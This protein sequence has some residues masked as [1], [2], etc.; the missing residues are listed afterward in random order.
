MEMNVQP[1][2]NSCDFRN[3][4]PAMVDLPYP[5][6]QVSGKNQRYADLLSIDYCGQSSEMSAIMQYINQENKLAYEKCPFAKI[7]L[8]IAMSEM[9]HLQKLGILI[10]LLGGNLN[11]TVRQSNGKQVMW[12]PSYLKTPETAR[13]MMLVNI[14]SERV[15]INQYKMHRNIIK[16]AHVNAV[17]ERII[18]DEEYHIMLLKSLLEKL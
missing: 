13:K 16:D 17:L 3:I 7:I 12:T 4:K 8:G 10:C 15:A 2:N 6:T 18:K 14:E 5:P 9:I 1:I 11:F